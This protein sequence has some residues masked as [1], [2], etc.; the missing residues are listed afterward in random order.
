MGN[1]YNSTFYEM[2]YFRTTVLNLFIFQCVTMSEPF[3]HVRTPSLNLLVYIVFTVSEFFRIFRTN[4]C[5]IGQPKPPYVFE[6]FRAY[7]AN[8]RKQCFLECPFLRLFAVLTYLLISIYTLSLYRDF[9]GLL[10]KLRRVLFALYI[11]NI[12]PI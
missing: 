3:G 9:L 11:G 8:N 12:A 4:F 10:L 2:A 6:L 7:Y 1:C 5:N